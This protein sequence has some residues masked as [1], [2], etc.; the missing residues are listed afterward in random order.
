MI[1]WGRLYLIRLV[2]LALRLL[3]LWDQLGRF[4]WDRLDPWDL[5]RHRLSTPPS[6]H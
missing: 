2:L 5:I 3:A 6:P 4:Q 1:Q